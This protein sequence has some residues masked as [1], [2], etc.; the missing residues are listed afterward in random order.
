MP[1]PVAHS[2]AGAAIYAALDEDGAMRPSRRLVAAVVLANAPDLD[3]VPGILAGDPN[4]FHHGFT[5]TLLTAVV[6]AAVAA[7]VGRCVGAGWPLRG[8]L[9]AGA[10]GLFLMV[11]VAWA[12]HVVLDVLTHDPSP[13]VGVPALWPLVDERFT[14]GPLFLRADKVAGQATAGEFFSSLLSVHNLAAVTVEAL[15]LAPLVVAARWSR[16]RIRRRPV[17]D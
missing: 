9:G 17:E 2:L 10:R 16:H 11:A 3:L 15:L 5:H 12:S 7:C 13:P 1:L 14:V 6:V 8:G 4:R